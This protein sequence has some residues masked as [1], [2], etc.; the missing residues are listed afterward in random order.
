[1]RH[2]ILK[3]LNYTPVTAALD[4]PEQLALVTFSQITLQYQL[5][6]SFYT[7]GRES[8]IKIYNFFV[9][10]CIQIILNKNNILVITNF[11]LRLLLSMIKEKHYRNGTC[12]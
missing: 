1:M 11:T 2:L 8:K 10:G 12:R 7:Y 5:F 3:N 4:F 9:Q 6:K